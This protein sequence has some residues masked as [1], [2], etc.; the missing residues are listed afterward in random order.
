MS[1]RVL[2]ALVALSAACSYDLDVL[3]GRRFE[4]IDASVDTLLSDASVDRAQPD[5]ATDTPLGVTDAGPS[6]DASTGMCVLSGVTPVEISPSPSGV[7]V[8]TEST[9][10]GT[11]AL[12]PSCQSSIAMNSTR[13]FRYEVQSGPHLLMTTNTG[14]CGGRDTVLAAYFS[15]DS[16]GGHPTGDVNCNDD[17]AVDL[18]ARCVDAGV[19]AGCGLTNSTLDLS[20]LVP[21]DIVYIAVSSYRESAPGPFRMAIAENGLAPQV[22]PATMSGQTSA[23]RCACPPSG[24]PM[25]G[26]IP[27]PRADDNNHLATSHSIFGAHDL[28]FTHVTGVSARLAL[29]RY[30]VDTSGPCAVS[31]GALAAID[32]LIGNTVVATGRLGIGS[33][34][35]GFVTIP[36]TSFAPVVFT[37]TAGIPITYQLRNIEPEGVACVTLD[38][39]LSAPNTVTLYGTN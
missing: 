11:S 9:A 20:G 31:N 12:I 25:L 23:N 33:G 26:D 30:N 2:L 35:G 32:L 24:T 4:P 10:G 3:K 1:S 5:T 29:T 27:F 39:D 6:R 14:F 17:D 28:P 38:V 19:L 13:V 37:L 18:C 7:T 36:F 21:H 22:P 34:A 15:C 8:I 16:G